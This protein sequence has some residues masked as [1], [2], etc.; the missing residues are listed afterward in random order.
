ML[1]FYTFQ[2]NNSKFKLKCVLNIFYKGY[3][4]KL[5]TL[6]CTESIVQLKNTYF[7]IL[8]KP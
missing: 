1:N 4:I 2:Y 8:I 3:N 5:S 6:I 7:Y